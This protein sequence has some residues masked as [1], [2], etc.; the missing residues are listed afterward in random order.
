MVSPFHVVNS[1]IS[2][3]RVGDIFSGGRRGQ[4]INLKVETCE[5]VKLLKVEKLEDLEEVLVIG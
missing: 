5:S 1:V 3:C 4:E 2:R